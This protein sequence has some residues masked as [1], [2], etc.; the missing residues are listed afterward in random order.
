MWPPIRGLS[1]DASSEMPH[2]EKNFPHH[3]HDSSIEPCLKK[4]RPDYSLSRA[5]S[6]TDVYKE[7]SEERYYP[8]SKCKSEGGR[9][10]IDEGYKSEPLRHHTGKGDTNKRDCNKTN[11]RP[12]GPPER[13]KPGYNPAVPF[14][15][16]S[17]TFIGPLCQPPPQEKSL[18]EVTRDS[19]DVASSFRIATVELGKLA[20]QS[21]GQDGMDYEL[22][23]FYKELDELEAETDEPSKSVTDGDIQQR[24]SPYPDKAPAL[25]PA[26]HHHGQAPASQPVRPLPSTPPNLLSFTCHAKEEPRPPLPPNN[27]FSCVGQAPYHPTNSSFV[28]HA[29]PPPRFERP[30]PPTFIV[31]YGPP[32]PRYNYP[33]TFPRHG[34]PPPLQP[35]QNFTYN[36]RNERPSWHRSPIPP[37]SWFT[38]REMP[39]DTL[40]PQD[41]D[42][43]TGKDP[44][45]SDLSRLE[46]RHFGERI[47]SY[48]DNVSHELD[49]LGDKKVLVLLR[50]VPGS[51]KST[52]ARTL[53]RQSPDGIVLSTDDYFCQE[54]GYTYHVNRL[55]DAHSWN[56][57]RARR[58][59]DDG[60]SPVI[61][62][63]TNIQSWE[64]KPYVQMAVDR[65][66]NV[67]FLEPDT[68]WKQDAHE[69]EKRNTHRVPREKIAQMLERYE[70]NMTVPVVMNSV[71]PRHVRPS[72]PPAEA[73]QRTQGLKEKCH[74]KGYRK[75]G[76]K[77]ASRKH[78]LSLQGDEGLENLAVEELTHGFNLEKCMI[79]TE[80]TGKVQ[81]K[82]LYSGKGHL[83]DSLAAFLSCCSN[84]S[85]VMLLGMV[86]RRMALMDSPL[87]CLLPETKLLV[88]HRQCL[89]TSSLFSLLV[90]S[91]VSKETN[92][93][94]PSFRQLQ[95]CSKDLLVTDQVHDRGQDIV[96]GLDLYCSLIHFFAGQTLHLLGVKN[97][98]LQNVHFPKNE[99][100]FRMGENQDEK[101]KRTYMECEK[102]KGL[103]LPT[104]MHPQKCGQITDNIYMETKPIT[105]GC[106]RRPRKFYKLAPTF[107]HPRVLSATQIY[108]AAETNA[109]ENPLE[110][111]LTRRERSC[112]AIC[113]SVS[114]E[115]GLCPMTSKCSGGPENEVITRPFLQGAKSCAQLCL[116]EEFARQIV[117]LFGCPGVELGKP[118]MKDAFKPKD[119]I[120]PL[121]NDLAQRIYLKWKASL[122]VKY[123]FH[124][125]K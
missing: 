80:K 105:P 53:L 124:P 47:L 78:K 56:Q 29:I 106:L 16:T 61:I 63:N 35:P 48:K 33:M 82:I 13:Q 7:F 73:R 36:T 51:G 108:H 65:G 72:L 94:R 5:K 116:P 26:N 71:E 60:R 87:T 99:L 39:Y 91:I 100:L 10:D 79:D 22:R 74:K 3:V 23:Q 104:E 85:T 41:R 40:F 59:L 62:D 42:E 117:E 28:S 45:H 102:V 44:Q 114:Y 54:N 101:S 109:M 57:N 66:Y 68:W 8:S 115:D 119:F 17:T 18:P 49:R 90:G 9:G 19:D 95:V 2:A 1:L 89:L 96:T 81:V 30:P 77:V 122:E 64:M 118:F 52:L 50:G 12:F 125:A 103:N 121:G 58:A 21:K 83:S 93:I 37:K 32:P 112:R 75:N 38:S 120:V 84:L 97:F 76:R 70:H 110:D 86:S 111:E 92:H 34:N 46:D 14:S 20:S 27:Q 4:S 25:H 98:K 55:G 43:R 123:K 24:I 88:T 67:E 31:P 6:H 69:L 113:E 11:Q 15:G 107:Q